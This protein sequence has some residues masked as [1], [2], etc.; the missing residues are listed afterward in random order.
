MSRAPHYIW[1]A[2]WGNKLGDLALVDAIFADAL[3]DP[4]LG[5]G[6][7]EIGERLEPRVGEHRNRQRKRQRVPAR[8]DSRVERAARREPS[9][10]GL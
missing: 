5:I 10:L 8:R 4:T 1:S 6:M 7:G 2:R 9:P 3:T